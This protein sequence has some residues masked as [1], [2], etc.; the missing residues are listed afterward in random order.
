MER[1]VKK[2]V[3]GPP[4]VILA[5]PKGRSYPRCVGGVVGNAG[6]FCVVAARFPRK[7]QGPRSASPAPS[8]PVVLARGAR[9]TVNG[10]W[11]EGRQESRVGGLMRAVVLASRTSG[12]GAVWAAGGAGERCGMGLALSASDLGTSWRWRQKHGHDVR[13]GGAVLAVRS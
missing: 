9:L 6:A 1:G 4:V 12:L 7:D 8:L 11:T 5:G 13:R 3:G 2:G 10:R